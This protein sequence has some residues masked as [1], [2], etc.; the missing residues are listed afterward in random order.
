MTGYSTE[1]AEEYRPEVQK[2]ATLDLKRHRKGSLPLVDNDDDQNYN[3]SNGDGYDANV[4][5]F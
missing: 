1:R 4:N 5:T 2:T 3:V